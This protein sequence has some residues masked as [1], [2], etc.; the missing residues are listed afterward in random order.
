M[1]VLP[2]P[3]L[4]Q[5]TPF[6]S[7]SIELMSLSSLSP[8]HPSPA[9]PISQWLAG[10]IYL[11]EGILHRALAL[12]VSLYCNLFPSPDVPLSKHCNVHP[13][14]LAQTYQVVATCLRGTRWAE[15]TAA[16]TRVSGGW[17]ADRERTE[18]RSRQT[19][20]S[21]TCSRQLTTPGWP[22]GVRGD[23]GQKGV[24]NSHKCCNGW[25]FEFSSLLGSERPELIYRILAFNTEFF[26]YM[27]VWLRAD[28]LN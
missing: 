8:S 3:Q 26:S 10:L 2:K 18:E 21:D 7:G 4:L 1:S 27:L 12:V 17:E 25:Y 14:I 16:V 13:Q 11:M 15:V 9:P 19:E 6:L 22:G 20:M 28:Y 23:C 5:S 24:D